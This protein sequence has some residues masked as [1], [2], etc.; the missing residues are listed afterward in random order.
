M[1]AMVLNCPREPLRASAVPNPKP[2]LGEV[3]IRIRACAVC[4]TDLHIIDGE[5]PGPK[6][7]LV[8]GHEIIGVV[9][10]KGQDAERFKIGD[11]VGVPWLGW[12]CGVCSYCKSGRE[13]LCERAR[14]TGYHVPGG[15]AERT[16]ADQRYCFAL[17]DAFD[18][19]HAAPLLCAGLIGYRALGLA[20][21]AARLGLYGMG[22]A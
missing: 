9:A 16:I 19:A 8:P 11:R 22:S 6:L 5:L 1:R 17:P 13:N 2:G 7:P 3:L 18:D 20:G 12:A 21:D 10:E 4:R 14:F 15:Y